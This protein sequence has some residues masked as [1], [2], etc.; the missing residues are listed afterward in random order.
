M[1]KAPGKNHRKVIT[2]KQL[3]RKFPTDAKAEEWIVKQRWP[4]GVCCPHCG[5]LNV[6][7]GCQHK[8]MPF[9][10]RERICAKRFSTK[11]GTVMEGSKIGYQDWIVA[12]LLVMTSLKSVPSMKLHRDLG[13]TQKSAWFLTQRLRAALSEDSKLFSGPVEVDKTSMGGKRKNMSNAQRKELADS[14]RGPFDHDTVKHSLSEY[15]KGEVHTNGIESL[16]SLLKRAH[17]GT[18]HK[19]SPKHLDRY[20]QEFAGRH[21]LRAL[22][23]INQIKGIRRG[24]EGKRLTYKAL[25]KD[26]G[27]QSGARAVA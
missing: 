1:A 15:A 2:V 16:W 7:T 6:Q 13:I 10:C 12:A 5:S 8:T 24:M 9:R 23:T 25:I 4:R 22:E 17:T 26:N 21:N 19:L 14:G 18:F 3:L 11:T 27:L 20:V